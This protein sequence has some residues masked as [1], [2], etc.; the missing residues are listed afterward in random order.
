MSEIELSGHRYMVSKMNVFDQ[1][2]VA[3]KVAPVIAGMGR[4]YAT[5]LSHLP[6]AGRNGEDPSPASQNEVIFEALLPITEILAKM[7]DEDV[8]YVLKKCLSVCA[9]HNGEQWVAMTRNGNLMFEDTDLSTLVQL[10][11]EVVKDNLNPSLFGLIL[12]FSAGGAPA[13]PLNGLE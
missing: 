8:N 3:R 10:V 6:D 4:G 13:S 5:A 11:M 1:A 9:R 12:P 2:H 7:S